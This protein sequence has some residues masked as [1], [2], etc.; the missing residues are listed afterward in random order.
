MFAE[1]PIDEWEQTRVAFGV[2]PF[3]R[4]TIGAHRGTIEETKSIL[5]RFKVMEASSDVQERSSYQ[6]ARARFSFAQ[7]DIREALELAEHAFAAHAELGFGAE[8]VK[9]ALV[10]AGEAAYALGDNTK[11]EELVATV[12]A[13]PPGRTTRFLRAQT[14]RFQALLAG[15]DDMVAAERAFGA[16]AALFREIGMPF[17]L[18][19]VRL[20]HAELL[21]AS[22]RADECGPLLIEAR[23][24]FERL[25]ATPWLERL[26]A[27]VVGAT[28]PA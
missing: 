4:A 17:Y 12:T 6:C 11:L 22:D 24:T 25:R 10:V 13:L 5:D 2:G 8:Q 26:D 18:A 28:T 21:V 9:E 27:L 1:L 19:V 14:S 7:G 23:E 20:E 16:A 3:I 15:S